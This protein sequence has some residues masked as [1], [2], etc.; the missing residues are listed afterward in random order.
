MAEKG[1]LNYVG[2]IILSGLLV[3]AGG[4]GGYFI[5]KSKSETP[6]YNSPFGI[7]ESQISKEKKL[8]AWRLVGTKKAPYFIDFNSEKNKNPKLENLVSDSEGNIKVIIGQVDIPEYK[9]DN[10]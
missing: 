3:F 8:E 2:K 7:Y 6:I 9:P 1:K 5:G 10:K 4:V